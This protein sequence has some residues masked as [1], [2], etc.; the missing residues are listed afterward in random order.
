[1][2]GDER[3][4]TTTRHAYGKRKRRPPS[5]KSR[6]ATSGRSTQPDE[7]CSPPRI[8]SPVP[9]PDQLPAESRPGPSTSYRL[10]TRY[11]T[12]E[13]IAARAEHADEVKRGLETKSATQRKFD[14]L[15]VDL[16]HSEEDSGTDFVVVDMAML[17]DLFAHVKCGKCGLAAPDLRKADRQYGLAVK[18][19]V[20]CSVCK[21]RVERFSSP[22]TE[23]SGNITPFEVNI[24]ALKS[25]QSIGKGVTA[26]S[27]FCAG[28]NLSHRGLHHKTF[29]AHLKKVVQVCEDTAAASEA[30]SVR[31]VKGLY[32]DLAQPA[33]NIDVMFDGT[34]MTRGRS[35]HIGVGCIIEVYTGLVIDHVVLSNFCLGCAIGP[36]PSDEGYE[37]WLAEHECQ[38]NIDCGAGRMEVEA[39]LILFKRSLS[40]NGLRYTTVMSDGDSRTM[41]GLKEEG[42]YGFVPIEKK[43][44]INH[45]CKRMHTSLRSVREKKKAQGETL[46]G[47]GKLTDQKIRKI[48]SYYGYALRSHPHDVPA[49]QKAVQATLRHMASTDDA[50]DH[51]LCPDGPS[52]W[53]K[54]NRA[55]ANGEE[56]PAHK[57][58][59]PDSVRAA[60]EPVFARLSDQALLER[61]ADGKT[62]NASE[63]LHSLIWTQASKNQHAS[64]LSVT[65]AVAE[66]VSVFNQGRRETNEGI[67]SGLGYTAG[68]CLLRRSL[69]KDKK[70]LKKSTAVFLSD[71]ANKRTLAR[72][73]KADRSTDY[74]PGQF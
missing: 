7:N 44:C 11:Y 22:R 63:C 69:E 8:A 40:K 64:L 37:D 9:S 60:L 33:N 56:P 25:I 50:P 16:E 36:K 31:V 38:R 23:G 32:R 15:E 2:P 52:S 70:R 28:M 26:L 71:D 18:L 59:L 34:W 48:A 51:S 58:A 10:D 6:G 43:D 12:A 47:R 62:Q 29:Q 57:D 74:S 73:H 41:H 46:G 55:V 14:L 66:A 21:H 72:R 3:L 1:M 53:C 17:K 45:V 54:Y 13:E 4:K 61:C 42:V 39:A 49:M 30:D 5:A 20:T 19:E 27:D 65:R 67:A 35:S 68:S 24:R